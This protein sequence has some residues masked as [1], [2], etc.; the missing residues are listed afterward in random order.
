M[1]SIRRWWNRWIEGLGKESPFAFPLHG[2]SVGIFFRILAWVF[3]L[4]ATPLS[5]WAS[6]PVVLGREPVPDTLTSWISSFVEVYILIIF[7][8]VALVGK[9]PS[10]WLPWR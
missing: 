10:S 5:V 9:A 8:R 2:Q 6:Y 3:V 4:F 1:R 7:W